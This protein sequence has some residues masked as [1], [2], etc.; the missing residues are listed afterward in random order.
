LES[1]LNPWEKAAWCLTIG[2]TAAVLVKLWTIGVARSYKALFSYLTFDFLASIVGLSIPY[3]SKWYGDFY[4]FAQTAK[5]VIAAF[6]LVEI[7]SLALE[8]HQALA[9]FGRGTVSYVLAAAALIPVMGL[10]LDKTA[11]NLHPYLRAFFLF[12]QT[13]DAT[14]GIF[15][16][17]ISI[18]MAWFPVRLRRNVV[19]YIS[20][21][22][23]WALTRAVAVYLHKQFIGNRPAMDAVNSIQICIT[24]GCLLFWIIGLRRAGEIRMAVVG[25][26][27]NR[28]EGERIAEQ[29][30][31]ING[32]LERLRRK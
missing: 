18:F 31:A 26:L 5:I 17:F 27:W 23:V 20:G 7:Y 28:A 9:R 1:L 6:V 25:H 19:V 11:N 21:F 24:V 3:V 2:L 29:L 22:V 15:L 12:E 8:H 30:D 10:I 14:I 16:I 4:F 32:S 13:M